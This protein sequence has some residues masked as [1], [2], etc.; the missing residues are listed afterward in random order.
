MKIIE[1]FIK[2][3]IETQYGTDYQSVYNNSPLIQYLDMKMGAVHGDSKKR[4]SLANIYAIYSILSFYKDDFYNNPE[5]YRQ[6]DGYDYMRLFNYYRKLYG[7]SKLQNHALNS[8][9]NGEFHNKFPELTNDLIIIDNGKYLLHIDYLYVNKK[10][11]SRTCCDI[12]AKYVELLQEKDHA[13]LSVLENMKQLKDYNEKKEQL[14][15]LLKEDAEAR[16]FEIISYAIL[17]NHYTN[18]RVFFGYT[19]ESIKENRLELYK[20]GRTNANDGGIDFVMRP[21]GRFFQVTEVNNYDKYL[22]DI[23]KVMHFPVTFVIKTKRKKEL[24]LKDLDR[25]INARANGMKVIKERYEK[26]IEEIITINELKEWTDSLG[27]ADV[28]GI[29]RDIDIYYRLEMN[30]DDEE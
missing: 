24:V 10:D 18:T 19:R 20:T 5:E 15:Q 14:N 3:I 28:D 30:M 1:S 22:L 11:I 26:A 16:I 13:L 27:N 9:V 6:F 12:I 29:I 4:R 17:K 23:D 21:V 25:Y 2:E 8:R 7:G